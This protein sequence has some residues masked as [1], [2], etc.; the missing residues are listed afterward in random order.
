[1]PTQ[2][3]TTLLTDFIHSHSLEHALM[4]AIQTQGIITAMAAAPYQINPSEWIAIFWGQTD[5][6][7]D[8]ENQLEEFAHIVVTIWNDARASL[9]ANTWQW[10]NVCA[11]DEN[12]IVN[13]ATRHF[14]EGLL[15][16]WQIALNDWQTVMPEHDQNA[17]LLNGVLLSISLLFD[18][19][20]ILAASDQAMSFDQFEEMFNAMP[21]MLC[22]ISMRAFELAG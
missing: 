8:H 7:F 10:P 15:Q 17:A 9:L 21:T 1:M 6:P 2:N 22:G 14:C 20:K 19:E 3:L 5:S 4:P 12:E 16:G 18:P 13:E 11:M